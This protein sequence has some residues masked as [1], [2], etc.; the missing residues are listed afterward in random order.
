MSQ[1]EAAFKSRAKSEME[2]L[3]VKEVLCGQRAI[4]TVV[5]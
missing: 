2:N 5:E 3:E 4:G 1:R